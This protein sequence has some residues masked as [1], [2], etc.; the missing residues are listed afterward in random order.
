M[1]PSD[2]RPSV[3]QDKDMLSAPSPLSR[4]KLK[5]SAG[6]RAPRWSINQNVWWEQLGELS[7]VAHLGTGKNHGEYI[8]IV[9]HGFDANQ[10]LLSNQAAR[11]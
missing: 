11:G 4:V 5:S 8:L 1:P 2:A 3:A 10:I 7:A 6:T 9:G